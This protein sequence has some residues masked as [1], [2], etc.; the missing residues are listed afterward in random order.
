VEGW[1]RNRESPV[2]GDNL[3]KVFVKDELD[4]SKTP[5]NSY[6]RDE[7]APA[8]L[9]AA[10]APLPSALTWIPNFPPAPRVAHDVVQKLLGD[11]Q[12]LFP[13]RKQRRFAA[14]HGYGS[15]G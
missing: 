4:T 6:E 5:F 13:S 14:V 11:D 15:I 7:N 10:K 2:W 8:D 1:D 12:A 9:T 3:S